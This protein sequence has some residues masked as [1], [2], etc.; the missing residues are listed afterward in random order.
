MGLVT[1]RKT[2]SSLLQRRLTSLD[3]FRGLT[4]ALMILVNNPGGGEYYSFLQHADWNG[5]TFADVVFPFFIFIMGAVIPFS[6]G[7]RVESGETKQKLLTRIIRRT[8]ILFALGLVING[9]PYYNLATLRIMGVLQRIALC[10]FFASLTFLFVGK[11]RQ[12]VLMAITPLVYWMLMVLIPV[13]GY[14]AGMLDKQGNLA[15]YIDR[16]LLGKHLYAGAWDP[17]GLLSTLPAFATALTGVLTG[18]YLRSSRKP[19]NKI[20]NLFLFGILSLAIGLVWNIWFPI[21]KNLWTSSY[22]AFTS[23]LSIIAL[24]ACYYLIDTR[25]RRSL[26]RP[27]VILGMNAITIYFLSEIINLALIY[28]EIPF[29]INVALKSL[30]YQ[31][32]FASWAG[33]LNVHSFMP[34]G[35]WLSAGS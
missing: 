20:M 12:V 17:E 1:I 18:Q 30:I 26:T 2:G 14:G 33:T 32:L 16:L 8:V 6:F 25:G 13:P 4:I 15:A 35:T 28:A 5:L 22:V 24:T 27:L 34:L 3:F 11:K 29:G 21:N 9:F 23:S 31:K 7:D 10:Y 19:S